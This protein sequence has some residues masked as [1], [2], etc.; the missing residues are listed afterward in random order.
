MVFLSLMRLDLKLDVKYIS[1]FIVVALEKT[2][3]R[4]ADFIDFVRGE[5]MVRAKMLSLERFP[6]K[7]LSISV[8][9]E[10]SKKKN[11]CHK[12]VQK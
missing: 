1:Y 12:T 8:T 6:D 5:K 2:G 10:I 9:S 4:D 11:R 7:P 3:H